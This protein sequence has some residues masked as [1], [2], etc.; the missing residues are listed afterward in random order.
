MPLWHH[1]RVRCLTINGEILQMQICS[2]FNLLFIAISRNFLGLVT[3]SVNLGSNLIP[4][5]RFL[6]TTLEFS[7]SLY[8]PL[9]FHSWNIAWPTDHVPKI[10]ETKDRV[11]RSPVIVLRDFNKDKIALPFTIQIDLR[12]INL[13]LSSLISH[14]VNSICLFSAP[15]ISLSYVLKENYTVLEWPQNI[16]LHWTKAWA[17]SKIWRSTRRLIMGHSWCQCHVI[18][19]DS[20]FLTIFQPILD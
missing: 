12:T 17:P 3:F 9:S 16:S 2:L 14:P 7:V 13:P 19:L 4:I 10:H 5:M 6:S 15:L 11:L 8:S 20:L 18:Q 1:W